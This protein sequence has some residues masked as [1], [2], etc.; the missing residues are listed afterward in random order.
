LVARA[1]FLFQL[2]GRHLWRSRPIA[3][4]APM[5]LATG[6]QAPGRGHAISF[7]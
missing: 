5:S 3:Q 1:A 6:S 7:Q 2:L 4:G